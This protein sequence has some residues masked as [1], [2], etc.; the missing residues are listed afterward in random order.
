MGPL[1]IIQN[2]SQSLNNFMN[3]QWPKGSVKW[4][5]EEINK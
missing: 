1:P 5:K 2:L 3:I 4:Q